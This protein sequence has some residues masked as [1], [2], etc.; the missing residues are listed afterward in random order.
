MLLSALSTLF[1]QRACLLAIAVT[2]ASALACTRVDVHVY[3]RTPASRSALA[4]G[5]TRAHDEAPVGPAIADPLDAIV[6]VASVGG[7]CTGTLI[8]PRVVLTS[9]ACH[10]RITSLVD[11]ESR[12]RLYA[13]LGGG[14]VSYRSS[15]VVSTVGAPCLPLVALVLD[16][17]LAAPPIRMRLGATVA[18]GEP[19]RVVG[20]GV[21]GP[22][23]ASV[24]AVG[25]AGKVTGGDE[26]T[27]ALDTRRCRGDAGAP[28]ISDWTGEIVGVVLD[29][30]PVN[31]DA[32]RLDVAS[33]L[34]SRAWL[35]SHGAQFEKPMRCE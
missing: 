20:F 14:V 33:E 35:E 30:D 10:L 16:E 29:D 34:L 2:A 22:R 32:A 11:P 7:E 18:M 1:A 19:V 8:A 13:G 6:R 21:C 15:R 9:R 3:E 23:P 31:H 26:T 24:R 5:R 25:F 17:S 27:F 12:D 4:A 28:V